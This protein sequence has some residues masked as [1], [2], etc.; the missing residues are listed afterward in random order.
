MLPFCQFEQSLSEVPEERHVELSKELALK[1]AE[2]APLLV[3][4]A[5]LVAAIALI[6][7][8]L[9]RRSRKVKLVF[10]Q[11]SL[12]AIALVLFL[13]AIMI[14]PLVVSAWVQSGQ[15]SPRSHGR[16]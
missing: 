4:G 10:H 16:D 13:I 14:K 15:L 8:D 5:W 6:V 9:R 1:L 2:A 7:A 11:V 12:V 3:L